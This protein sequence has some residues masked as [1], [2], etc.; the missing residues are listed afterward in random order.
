ME[1]HQSPL[2]PDKVLFKA[3]KS[4]GLFLVVF[5][6]AIL[7]CHSESVVQVKQGGCDNAKNLSEDITKTMEI[8]YKHPLKHKLQ[9]W[10]SG[11]SIKLMPGSSRSL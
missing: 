6:K 10:V 1:W 2:L 8:K 3:V 5:F 7:P 9:N 11:F 4:S